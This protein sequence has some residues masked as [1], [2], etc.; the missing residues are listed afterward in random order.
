MK[1]CL[2]LD[3]EGKPQNNVQ[4]IFELNLKTESTCGFPLLKF[5][6]FQDW[7]LAQNQ[8]DTIGFSWI[9]LDFFPTHFRLNWT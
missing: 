1:K 2:V 6:F 4:Y 5:E 9:Q 8:L 3:V 7:E